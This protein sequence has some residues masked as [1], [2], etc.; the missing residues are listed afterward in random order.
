[1]VVILPLYFYQIVVSFCTRKLGEAYNG[2]I[3]SVTDQL[4]PLQDSCGKEPSDCPQHF[5]LALHLLP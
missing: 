3:I 2:R 5:Q 1:M 4:K